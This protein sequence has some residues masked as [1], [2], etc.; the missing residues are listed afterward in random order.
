MVSVN[1]MTIVQQLQLDENV[2]EL[3]NLYMDDSFTVLCMRARTGRGQS[4]EMFEIRSTESF[5]PLHTIRIEHVVSAYHYLNGLLVV[6]SR[7]GNSQV[8]R[9]S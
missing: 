3:I 6:G 7:P 2:E 1:E 8:L 5:A 9:Y 4:N